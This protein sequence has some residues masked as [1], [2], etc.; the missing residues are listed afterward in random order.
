[1]PVK[2]WMGWQGKGSQAKKKKLFLLLLSLDR[3]PA[4]GVAQIKR[5]FFLL[6]I[7]IKDVCLL[8]QDPQVFPPFLD[9]SS[10]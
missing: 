5:V 10:F 2:E 3:L 7:W 6:N 9:C 4:E 1:M 8:D